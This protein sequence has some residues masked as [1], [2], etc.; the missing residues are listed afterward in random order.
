MSTAA[1]VDPLGTQD[2]FESLSEREKSR[3]AGSKEDVGVEAKLRKLKSLEVTVAVDVKLVGFDGD[4]HLSI[5]IKQ[6]CPAGTA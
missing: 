4:G 1:E 2:P 6:V 3:W 5:N